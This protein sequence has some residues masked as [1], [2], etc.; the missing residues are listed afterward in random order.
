MISNQGQQYNCEQS[1]LLLKFILSTLVDALKNLMSF[2]K[3]ENEYDLEEKKI[4]VY[5]NYTWTKKE[6]TITDIMEA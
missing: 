3:D 5:S 2:E 1:G 6:R 4:S